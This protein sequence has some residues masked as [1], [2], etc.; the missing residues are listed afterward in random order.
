MRRLFPGG[1]SRLARKSAAQPRPPPP[2]LQSPHQP[3]SL[4]QPPRASRRAVATMTTIVGEAR[5]IVGTRIPDRVIEE[6]RIAV[7]TMTADRDEIGERKRSRR[8]LL[9]PLLAQ[10]PPRCR[11]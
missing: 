8:R 11:P 10:A 3:R 7:R 6:T 4:R 2:T 1:A 5:K 9:R